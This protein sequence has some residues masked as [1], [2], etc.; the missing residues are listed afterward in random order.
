MRVIEHPV[1]GP[2]KP[3]REITIFF[4]GAPIQAFEDEPVAAALIN[5]GVKAFRRTPKRREPRGV[6]CC[7]DCMMVIDGIPNVR[8][9]ITGA[10]DGMRVE[11]QDG[12][13]RRKR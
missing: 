5:A 4:N 9:C 3:R 11:T 10:K 13:V 8:T 1:L 7:T 2:L 12:L 6:F